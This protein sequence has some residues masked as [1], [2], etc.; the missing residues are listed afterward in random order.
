MASK[1]RQ[2]QQREP[3]MAQVTMTLP[4]ILVRRLDAHAREETRSRSNAAALLLERAL[5][6]A[7]KASA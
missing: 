2:R 3:E 4:A 1:A 5:D 6:S 7:A